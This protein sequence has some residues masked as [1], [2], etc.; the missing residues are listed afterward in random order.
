MWVVEAIINALFGKLAPRWFLW[1]SFIV[2]AILVGAR[3]HRQAL[4]APQR[5][6]VGF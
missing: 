1:S 2:V 3:R 4:A 5:R 6:T